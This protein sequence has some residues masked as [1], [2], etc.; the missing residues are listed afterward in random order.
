MRYE[1]PTVPTPDHS[2][3]AD[4][5]DPAD[6]TEAADATARSEMPTWP[7]EAERRRRIHEVRPIPSGRVREAVFGLSLVGNFVLL[8][9]VLGVLALIQMGFFAQGDASRQSATGLGLS[10]PTASSSPFP[11]TSPSPSP[12]STPTALQV[13][14]SSVQ[15][16][17]A[18]GQRTQVVTLQNTG[19]MAV[20]WH[21]TV[22]S[23]KVGVAVS[24]QQGE[25]AA[26]GNISI[27]VQTTTKSTGPQ[28]GAG[29]QGVIT[30]M[31][32]NPDGSQPAQLSYT[33]VGCH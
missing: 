30:F 20:Q 17:C 21:A 24:P 25:L 8:T 18:S 19:P 32:T 14:P 9:S 1:G 11:S 31:S 33:T 22:S 15:L 13:T 27:Q 3:P 16:S 12:S 10:N 2:V 6:A 5:A 26:G 28:G 29:Q 4:P 7:V 23:Q